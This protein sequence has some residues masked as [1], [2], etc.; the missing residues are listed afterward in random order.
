M[1]A[2]ASNGSK[3]GIRVRMGIT[4]RGRKRMT[5]QVTKEQVY[6]A[7]DAMRRVGIPVTEFRPS[8]DGKTF[9]FEFSEFLDS[10]KQKQANQIVKK[11]MGLNHESEFAVEE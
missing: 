7:M 6:A 8:A 9:V 2:L 11:Y 5:K 10:K 4:I 1:W 3:R